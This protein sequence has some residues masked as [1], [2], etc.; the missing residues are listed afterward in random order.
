MYRKLGIIP[1]LLGLSVFVCSVQ[2]AH[3]LTMPSPKTIA[4][5]TAVALYFALH[6]KKSNPDFQPRYNLKN[7]KNV[8]QIT[9]KDYWKNLWYLFNDGFIGQTSTNNTV[10]VDTEKKSLVFNTNKSEA[11]GVLGTANEYIKPFKSAVE[12][13]GMLYFAYKLFSN[14]DNELF[15]NIDAKAKV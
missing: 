14:L 4:L 10:K 11:E 8:N 2:P 15:S 13:A 12:T 7:I 9:T 6:V 5:G 1:A 3:A